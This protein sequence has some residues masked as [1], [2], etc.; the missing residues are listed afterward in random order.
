MLDLFSVVQDK[1][2]G[3]RG[4]G[5]DFLLEAQFLRHHGLIG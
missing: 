4:Q 1:A 3:M 2:K 5:A